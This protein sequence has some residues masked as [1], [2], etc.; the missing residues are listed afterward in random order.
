VS[1]AWGILS[2]AAINDRVLAE[3]ADSDDVRV[4]A[5]ASREPAKARSYAEERGI[6]RAY[7]SYEALLADPD[8]EAVYVNLP[9][10]LHTEWTL[11]ALDAGKH[12]LCE[13][14]M[15]PRAADVEQVFELAHRRRLQVMEAFMYRHNPQTLRL[16]ELVRGGAVGA[17]KLIRSGF[18]FTASDP[19]DIRLS[20]ALEGGALMDVG[21][22]C[23]NISRL[24]VGEPARVY[25]EATL[26]ASGVD[27][28]FSG[29]L[30][31]KRDVI[32]LFDAS[33]SLP[34][35]A[36]IEIFGE[37]GSLF[38]EDPWLCGHP[39]IE[40][41]REDTVQ[42]IEVQTADS[43]RLEFENFSAAICGE[44]QPRIGYEDA[45]GQARTIEALLL[46]ARE[47]R[48]IRP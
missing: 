46:S 9:N 39:G 6:E 5:V 33:V 15:T 16:A 30:R 1:V 31:T 43:Y 11:H 13:K 7:A 23:V 29:V 19:N 48:S 26:G 17:V 35:R 4:V 40:I 36:E 3:L 12:V 34:A 22:Y 18:R 25:G 21:A 24:L 8:V 47:H 42:H 27:V 37:Q 20:A 41:R 28:G 2:T 44:T 14:P 45:L 38:V 10:S 32:S